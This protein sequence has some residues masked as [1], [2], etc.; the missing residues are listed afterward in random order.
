MALADRTNRPLHP[1]LEIDVCPEQEAEQR[2]LEGWYNSGSENEEAPRSSGD[3]EGDRLALRPGESQDSR[4]RRLRMEAQRR[5]RSNPAVAE[6]QRIAD[7]DR[8]RRKAA[9]NLRDASAD[10]MLEHLHSC[11]GSLITANSRRLRTLPRGTPEH[12]RA[13]ADTAVDIEANAHVPIEV[14]A[15][16]AIAYDQHSRVKMCVCGACGLRDPESA[17]VLRRLGG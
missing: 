17:Q 4:T 6:K 2:R 7:Q 3:S 8:H 10:A 5:R 11:S 12:E 16:C 13:K 15:E 1:R 14:K 9:E